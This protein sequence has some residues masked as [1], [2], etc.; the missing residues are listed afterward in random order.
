MY[1]NDVAVA[2]D[3][4]SLRRVR[5]RSPTTVVQETTQEFDELMIHSA[6]S[7]ADFQ[8]K[9]NDIIDN[10]QREEQPKA[11]AERSS[12]ARRSQPDAKGRINGK[13]CHFFAFSELMMDDEDMVDEF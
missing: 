11:R 2:V 8:G 4:K 1:K 9:I 12:T 7:Y 3:C 10:Q 5:R 13:E 6:S